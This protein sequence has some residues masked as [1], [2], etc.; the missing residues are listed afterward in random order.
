MPDSELQREDDPSIP[1]DELLWRRICNQPAWWKIEPGGS[2][3]PSS[4]AFLD[5]YTGE[6]SVN[7]ASLTTREKTLAG[8]PDDG[9]IEIEA[10][11]PRSLGHRVVSD[12]EPDNP[13][14]ALILPPATQTPKTRKA[15]ARRMAEAAR[16][17]V[18]PKDH[19]SR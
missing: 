2:L 8:R 4:V 14:H 10:A 17:L 16:W 15:D 7:R 6:V 19:R 5:S 11:F 3:R 13:A 12:P 1:D 9:L 18:F